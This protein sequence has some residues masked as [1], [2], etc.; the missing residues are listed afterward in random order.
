MGREEGEEATSSPTLDFR[1][2]TFDSSFSAF[3]HFSISVF[4]PRGG[5]NVGTGRKFPKKVLVP[6]YPVFACAV[7]ARRSAPLKLF[8]GI[9]QLTRQ[10]L[11]GAAYRYELAAGEAV[12]KEY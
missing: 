8:R 10:P 3:Q 9:C 4:T 5:T 7:K 11:L 12:Q 6:A 1:P 2:W